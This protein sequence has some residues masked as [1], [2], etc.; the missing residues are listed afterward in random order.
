GPR[1][2]SN[3]V[4]AGRARAALLG[5]PHVTPEDIEKV[6]FP[7]LRH[8]VLPSF[9]AQADGIGPDEITRRIIDEVKQPGSRSRSA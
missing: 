3:L 9:V 1:A 7:I 5:R 6:A 2:S 4:L 8:R